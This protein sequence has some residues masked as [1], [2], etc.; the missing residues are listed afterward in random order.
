MLRVFFCAVTLFAMSGG[1]FGQVAS[2]SDVQTLQALL[3]EVRALRQDL[4]AS[5]S[6]AQS[7][8]ILLARFQIQEGV[9]TRASDRLTEARQKLSDT[10]IHQRDLT[11]ELK[12]L[13]DELNS[14]ENPQQQADLQD[15]MKH[16]KSDLE[17]SGSIAQQQ[18]AAET[19]AD[20]QFRDEQNKLNTIES[21]LDDIIRS[22]DRTGEKSSSDR[23]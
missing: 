6:R 9:S 4:R 15:R 3:S 10:Q 18:Q 14:A 21:Q 7:M 2:S 20:Q 19:Q 11:L 23:P 17:L 1:A 5:L 8:Q 16:V 13:E 12:R 22:A